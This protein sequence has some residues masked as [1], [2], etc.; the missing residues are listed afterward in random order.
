MEFLNYKAIKSKLKK[1][2]ILFKKPNIED[3][4]GQFYALA[5]QLDDHKLY[6]GLCHLAVTNCLGTDGQVGAFLNAARSFSKASYE[7]V[8][9]EDHVRAVVWIYTEALL[10]CDR[11]FIKPICLE[12]GRFYESLGMYQQAADCFKQSM[13]IS[14][15]VYN[16]ILSKR[17]KSAL[18]ELKNCPSHLM[19]S[20][21]HTSMFLLELLLNEDIK[22]L[23]M[24]SLQ[25]LST[26]SE[27]TTNRGA[28]PIDENL[29]DLNGLLE[30]LMI[31]LQSR[32]QNESN[33]SGNKP[34]NLK[35][36][37]SIVNKLSAFLNPAQIQLL[38]LL[39][40]DPG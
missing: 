17:Y 4:S 6:A 20:Q 13:S 16:L 33:N 38:Y 31:L 14:R 24:N 30:S 12:M 5:R 3:A 32:K 40:E 39:T 1:R 9:P 21:D 25:Q 34:K 35:I 29:Y 36:K 15:C 2:G 26:S 7:I 27:A 19:T 18:D 8:S 28:L 37:N 10:N 11:S 23:N 22:E